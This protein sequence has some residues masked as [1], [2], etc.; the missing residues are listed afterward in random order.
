MKKIEVI[1]SPLC[2]ACGAF[3]GQLREW[4]Q[5]TDTEIVAVPFQELPVGKRC[6]FPLNE[7]CFLDVFYEGQKIDSV[8]LHREKIYTAL[9]FTQSSVLEARAVDFQQPMD[10]DVFYQHLHKGDI[11]FSPIT[12]A[13][14]LTE[15][16]MCLQNYPFGNPP[17]QFHQDCIRI[18]SCIFSEVL[19]QEGIAGVYAEY[20]GKVAGLLEVFPREIVKKYGY[21]TGFSEND[22]EVLSVGCYE[23]GAGMPR[24]EM[25]DALM[26]QLEKLYPRFHR[27]KLE[28]VGIYGWRDGFNPYWVYEKYGF[29]KSETLS[30]NTVVMR[31][32]I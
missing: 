9:G 2:E 24:V 30:E 10:T 6:A 11:R 23:V 22:T 1:Y 31:K 4:L 21:M 14:F 25:I 27:K 15:M 32:N 8:P 7:N 12:K 16:T 26:A 20:D 18:K 19:E 13:N 29:V 28:G 5:G 3:I 17:V